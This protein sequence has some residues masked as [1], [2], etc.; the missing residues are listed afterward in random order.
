MFS[1]RL[2]CFFRR[3]PGKASSHSSKPIWEKI[4]ASL[5]NEIQTQILSVKGRESIGLYCKLCCVP[6][7][8]SCFLLSV[9]TSVIMDVQ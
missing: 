1:H 4:S 5:L 9:K 3:C 7:Q 6:L 8:W 2:N